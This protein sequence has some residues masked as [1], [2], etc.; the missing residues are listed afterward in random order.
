[1]KRG[2]SLIALLMVLI[3]SSCKKNNIDPDVPKDGSAFDKMRDSVFLYAKQVY[4]WSDGLPSYSAFNPRSFSGTNE[5]NALSK[6]VDAF[7]QYNNFDRSPDGGTK[8]SFIDVGETAAELG[9]TQGDFG[10]APFYM[11]Q[12]DLRIKYVYPGSPAALAG[13]KR[14]YRVLSINNSTN[15]NYD[16]GGPI[17]EFVVNAFFYSNN[18]T[19][20]LERPDGSRFI[21]QVVANQYATN[22][23]LTYK[24]INGTYGSKIGYLVFNTFTVLKNAKPKLDEAF[25]FFA[26]NSVTDLIIDLRYNGGGSVLTAD[27]LTNLMAPR[28]KT[29]S[30]M[31]ATYYNPL[32][33]SGQASILA[34]QVRT[35][36]T[37]G[38]VYNYA[39]FDY[40]VNRNSEYFQKT[41]GLGGISKICFIVGGGTASASELV[42]NNMLGV[43]GL[44]DVKLIGNKTYGKPVGFFDIKINKYEMYIPEFETKNALGQGGYYSGMTPGSAQYPGKLGLDDV[45]RDFGDPQELLLSYALNYINNGA[46]ITAGTDLKV[47]SLQQKAMFSVEQAS[48]AQK[49]LDA[50]KFNGMVYDKPLKHK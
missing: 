22:P 6:E 37:T 1:M 27:Y 34:N 47:Q 30:L 19:L 3:W 12:N 10:F 26:A 43:T 38:E 46:F 42:I 33:T 23:V 25:N 7:S 16:D 15:F 4:Y 20:G 39:Q 18:I 5:L 17:T 36:E 31:Y 40:S 41:G 29:G 32:V 21:T 11:A 44:V 13:I 35:D 28:S 50:G 9:G 2:T 8:Y 49:S 14:G 24:V 48:A 45:T